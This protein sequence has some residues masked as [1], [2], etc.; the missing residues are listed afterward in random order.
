ML[1]LHMRRQEFHPDPE[2]AA[3]REQPG[4]QRVP[5]PYGPQAWLVT[6]YDDVRTVLRNAELFSYAHGINLPPMSE[7]QAKRLRAG[8]LLLMDPPDHTRL[9]R[10]LTPE[11]TMRRIRRL[12]PRVREIVADHLD[13]MEHTGAPADLISQFATPIPSLVICELLGVPY[14][15]RDAFQARTSAI[16]DFNRPPEERGKAQMASAAYMA[17]L[18]G[19]ARVEPGEDLIGMLV[20]E[21]GD[22]LSTDELVG[23]GGLLLVAGHETTASMIGLGTL[24]LL[25]HPEQLDLFRKDPD[26]VDGMV[27]ELL[28]WLTI[29]HAGATKVATADTEIAGVPIAKGDV[30]V[31]SLPAANRDPALTEDPDRFDIERPDLAHVAFGYGAHHCIG[32]PLARMEMRIAFPALFERFPGLRE[33]GE[34]EFRSFNVVYGLSAFPVAW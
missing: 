24:A 21:H 13:T 26:K 30:V 11:F 31:V 17:E 5:T 33:A 1:P 8:A 15:D 27:E 29:I 16:L 34:P 18:V 28:R 32:A 20:R 7:E 12:E 19:R 6:R 3:A 25:R 22:D 23:I 2:L 4:L 9:R 14:E 10:M